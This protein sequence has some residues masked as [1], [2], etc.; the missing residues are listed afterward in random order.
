MAA[1]N[2]S[3]HKKL[4]HSSGL[5]PARASQELFRSSRVHS[6]LLTRDPSFTIL[7][8]ILSLISARPPLTRAT[9][10]ASTR[11]KNGDGRAGPAF[12][13]HVTDA[14]RGEGGGGRGEEERGGRVTRLRAPPHPSHPSPLM[15]R[16]KCQSCFHDT[17]SVHFLQ[18]TIKER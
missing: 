8:F 11:P 18:T 7:Y 9:R 1:R 10:S 15:Q 5:S 4:F 3:S 6:R 12:Y 13:P 14:W 16:A 17:A 2:T